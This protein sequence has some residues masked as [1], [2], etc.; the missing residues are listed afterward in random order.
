MAI[1]AAQVRELREKTGLGMMLCKKALTESD[2]NMEIAIE[3]LR[4]QG[5]ATMEKRAGKAAKEGCISIV[6]E[7]NTVIMYEVNSETDFVARNDDFMAFSKELGS[8]LMAQRPANV[9]AALALT[10]PAWDGKSANDRLLDLT[11]KIG[12]KIGFRRF[13]IIATEANQKAYTYLH[14][15]K[16]GVTVVI[17]ADKADMLGSQAGAQ[18]GKD[19]AM[20]V[21]ASNPLGLNQQS[22]SADTVAK[23]REIYLT[24]AQ[25]SGKPEKI[26]D[27]IVEGK[28]S[29]FYSEVALVEQAYIKEPEISVQKRIDA[30]GTE[31]G[32]TFTVVS[33]IRFELGAGE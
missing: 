29:K 12:E 14:G 8:V 15:T 5:Q 17:T 19:L 26:W 13:V 16:I 18:L 6:E 32:G 30:A 25:T 21:A 2:G 24:Q 3:N 9:E 23:E 11:G 1:T 28:L 22:I 4:K 33:F 31:A 7:G 10:S 20:Q 27:K